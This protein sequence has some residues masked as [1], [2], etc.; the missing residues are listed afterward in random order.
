MNKIDKLNEEYEELENIDLIPLDM[1]EVDAVVK[2]RQ[3]I[4]K[5]IMDI[6]LDNG[7]NEV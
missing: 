1:E 5:E 6:E 7:V 2:R 4:V 3:K